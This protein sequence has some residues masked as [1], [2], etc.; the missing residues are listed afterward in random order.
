M[1]KGLAISDSQMCIDFL[2]EERGIDLDSHLSE[3]QKAIARAFRK[4]MEENFYW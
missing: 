4:M 2:N 3:E 1:Y